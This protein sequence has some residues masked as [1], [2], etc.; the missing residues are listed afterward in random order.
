MKRKITGLMIAGLILPLSV[1]STDAAPSK[2]KG[3]G[4]ASDNQTKTITIAGVITLSNDGKTY[5]IKDT[6]HLDWLNKM[7]YLPPSKFKYDEYEM[8]EV[9]AV[10]TAKGDNVVSVS[11]IRPLD[12]AAYEARQ[13][14]LK[15]KAAEEKK[16]TQKKK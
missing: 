4:A 9:E 7:W 8:L 5:V 3:P 10:C 13:K 14:E 15:E 6:K 1:L 12:K 16:S 2:S 11:K